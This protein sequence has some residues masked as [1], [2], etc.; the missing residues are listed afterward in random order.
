MTITIEPRGVAKSFQDVDMLNIIEP[1]L[2]KMALS[3]EGASKQV[4]PVD[5]G[6]LRSS[7]RV[8]GGAVGA[9]RT[10]ETNTHYARFVHDGT[11][12]MRARPFFRWGAL[13]AITAWEHG[14]WDAIIDQELRRQ[15]KS[16]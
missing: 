9:S 6:L 10:I 7:I 1:A 12:Y 5:T 3:I 14:R 16:L 8:T 11:K 4:T 13:Q 2:N 15:L